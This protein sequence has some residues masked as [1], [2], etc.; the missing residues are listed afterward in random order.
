MFFCRIEGALHAGEQV[1]SCAWSN[2]NGFGV[3]G[4]GEEEEKD[5]EGGGGGG[6]TH[7]VRL[8]EYYMVWKTGSQDIWGGNFY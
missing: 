3:D 4:K 1:R 8:M 6:S 7:V 2:F 5:E